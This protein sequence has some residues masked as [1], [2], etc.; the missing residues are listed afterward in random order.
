MERQAR[1]TS[2]FS[3][4]NE[5]ELNALTAKMN[6][7]IQLSEGEK[8]R[9][10]QLTIAREGFQ[11]ALKLAEQ[12]GTGISARAPIALADGSNWFFDTTSGQWVEML[13]G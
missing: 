6:A 12:S 8:N 1:E 9:A 4:Q 11:N 13:E 7:G 5:Q 3:T 10:N 2:M